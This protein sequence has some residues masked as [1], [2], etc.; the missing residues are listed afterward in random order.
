MP[1]LTDFDSQDGPSEPQKQS[2][3]VSESLIFNILVICF[4]IPFWMASSAQPSAQ[5]GPNLAQLG[6]NLAQIGPNL[7]QLGANLDPSILRN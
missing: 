7:A 1:H 5:L 6:P 3:R 2:S 4:R